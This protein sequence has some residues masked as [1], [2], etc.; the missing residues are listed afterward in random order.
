MVETT[1]ARIMRRPASRLLRFPVPD[2][3]SAPDAS[4]IPVDPAGNLVVV[5]HFRVGIQVLEG[6]GFDACRGDERVDFLQLQPD[7]ATEL[8]GGQLPFVDELVEG[9]Q[10]DTES[11]RRLVGGKPPDLRTCHDRKRISL[12]M[13]CTDV[14]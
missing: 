8:V 12:S 11:A 1:T 6:T 14:V 7:D 5:G 9:S 4:G 10:R 13:E 3:P 2:A